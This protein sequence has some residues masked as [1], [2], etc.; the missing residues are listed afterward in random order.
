M[1]VCQY[2][3]AYI[4]RIWRWASA[5]MALQLGWALQLYA[6]FVGKFRI[7]PVCW[8]YLSHSRH[9]YINICVCK[10]LRVPVYL[11]EV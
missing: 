9:I 6:V 5:P 1:Q 3:P 8:W 2:V 7:C 11:Y 10:F 4:R